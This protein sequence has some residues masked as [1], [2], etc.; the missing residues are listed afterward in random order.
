MLHELEKVRYKALRILLVFCGG[1]PCINF[2]RVLPASVHLMFDIPTRRFEPIALRKPG[3][4]YIVNV[5]SQYFIFNNWIS[6]PLFAI[7]S[8]SLISHHEKIQ[9]W[10][11]IISTIALKTRILQAYTSKGSFYIS[12]VSFPSITS[13]LK[14]T[15]RSD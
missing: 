12:I 5:R 9:V 8:L 6:K 14:S 4:I 10:R 15:T 13:W 11:A 7:I 1:L 2:F 3:I